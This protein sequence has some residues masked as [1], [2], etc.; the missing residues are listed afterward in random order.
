MDDKKYHDNEFNKDC[1]DHPYIPSILPKA[2]RIIVIGDIHGDMKLLLDSLKLGKVIDNNNKWI[3]GNKTIVVQIGDQNDSYRPYD[4]PND[5]PRGTLNDKADDINILEYMT[6]LHSQAIKNGGAVYSLLGNHEIMNVQGNISY[7][8]YQNLMEYV[9]YKD[10]KVDFKKI[11]NKFTDNK[12]HTIEDYMKDYEV[13]SPYM[14]DKNLSVEDVRKLK[15]VEWG[16]M[17]RRYMFDNSVRLKLACERIGVMI[18]GSFLFVHA[19]VIPQFFNLA[20]FDSSLSEE[21]NKKKMMVLNRNIRKW[22]LKIAGKGLVTNEMLNGKDSMFWT[23]ILGKIPPNEDKNNKKCV[24]YLE[25]ALKLF[26]INNM[27]I[28]HT[29]QYFANHVGINVTCGDKL[30]RVDVGSSDAFLKFDN[31][32]ISKERKAQVIEILNDETINIIRM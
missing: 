17:S 12:Q 29:P 24:K 3:K 11:R 27:V 25:P 30:W 9:D 19:G 32:Q 10:D 13:I 5:D 20:G 21:E 26:N 7:T 1:P 15:L 18:I 6:E 23:R 31:S 22:L 16:K 4:Y 2:E 8:S 14:T 28:G